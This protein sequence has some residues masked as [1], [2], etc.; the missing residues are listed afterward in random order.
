MT[1]DA[2]LELES[3]HVANFFQRK[4]KV[5]QATCSISPEPGIPTFCKNA[6]GYRQGKL[7]G[8]FMKRIFTEVP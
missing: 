7:I 8:Y 6:V 1:P 2:G 3:N 5:E 4:F